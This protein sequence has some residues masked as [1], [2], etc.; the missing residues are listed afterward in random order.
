MKT[1]KQRQAHG[2]EQFLE[3]DQT[4]Y[5]ASYSNHALQ[6]VLLKRLSAGHVVVARGAGPSGKRDDVM[7]G[8]RWGS[9][10]R[11][12]LRAVAFRRN[13]CRRGGISTRLAGAIPQNRVMSM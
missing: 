2:D 3:L 9:A 8:D 4:D 12:V 10:R 1:R 7:I 11:H 6:Q 5:E 13:G